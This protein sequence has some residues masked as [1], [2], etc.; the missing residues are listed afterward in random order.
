MMNREE[1]YDALRE[2][3]EN[4]VSEGV[5]RQGRFVIQEIQKNNDVT[6]HG[7]TLQLNEG[8]TSPIMY[9][10]RYFEAYENGK[11][12]KEIAVELKQEYE[13]YFWKRPT[14]KMEDFSFDKVLDKVFFKVIDRK[15]NRKKLQEVKNTP[16]ENGFAFVY[17]IYVNENASI[18]ITRTLAEDMTYDMKKIHEAAIKNTPNFYPATLENMED[19]LFGQLENNGEAK[20]LLQTDRVGSTPFGM[21]V[22]SNDEKHLG[23]SALYY[24]GVKEKVSDVIKGDYYVIPSSIHEVIII[25]KKGEFNAVKLEEM[26]REVNEN[27]VDPIDRFSDRVLLY[28]SKRKK[29]ITE[30]EPIKNNDERGR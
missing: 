30:A 14:I 16:I 17:S 11:S 28:D 24:P 9:L 7:I 3:V 6:L 8:G 2:A 25:P 20:N 27:T 15:M 22:L 26:V 23:A 10:E 13:M 21:L 29:L 19:V 12:M 5:K 4:A 18:P 1:F